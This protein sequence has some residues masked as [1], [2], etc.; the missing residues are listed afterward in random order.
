MWINQD[1]YLCPLSFDETATIQTV[2]EQCELDI[3]EVVITYDNTEILESC[4]LV[5]YSTSVIKP[6]CI[7]SFLVYFSID[8]SYVCFTEAS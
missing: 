6:I 5:D 4:R 1:G 7:L 3:D 8:D 2:L